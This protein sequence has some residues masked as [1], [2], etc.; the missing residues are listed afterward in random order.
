VSTLEEL[1]QK[2]KA[3]YEQNWETM[4]IR[5]SSITEAQREA[6]RL[7]SNKGIYQ[8]IEAVTHVPWFFVGLCHDRESAFN[9]NTYL[10]NGQPLNQV[11]TI[12]PKGRGPF[13]GPNAFI[14]G[15]VDALRLEGLVG[16]S[17]WSIA[18]TLFRLEAYNGFGYHSKGVNSP[19]L[20]SGSTVYGPPEQRA[21]K[22]VGDGVFNPNEV[23]PQLGVA[24]ILKELIGLDNS[25]TFDAAPAVPSGSPEPDV[26]HAETILQLQRSLNQ[27]GLN[28]K[29]V[30]DGIIGPRTMAAIS[31]FQ[32]QGGLND[33]GV[34]DAATIAAVA[35]RL[36]PTPS[37]APLP[38]IL[39]MPIPP[40]LSTL[41]TT[42]LDGFSQIVQ[43]LKDL[44]QMITSPNNATTQSVATTP[45]DPLGFL[46][47]VL[48]MAIKVNSQP[49]AAS[50]PAASGAPSANQL[51]QIIDMITA[52]VGQ[53]DPGLGQVN[54]AL[55]ETIGNLLNGKKTAIG[56]GGS[57]TT[58]LL[59]AVSSSPN[60]GGLAGLLGSIATS[61]PGLSQFALPI[62]LA[63][64]AWGVLGK[65]EKWSQGIVPQ[66]KL[67]A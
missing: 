39:P 10:G 63:M 21:G 55:G 51:K 49:G 42:M 32:Q 9:L 15:A 47:R 3:G 26:A 59:A 17:D 14:N 61:V 19:Y 20:W 8:K 45:N 38:P 40:I 29:L 12:V 28:P 30:E 65:F 33:T 7:L 36:T 41:P 48:G 50:T 31:S 13:L 18:R 60:A 6:N 2:F 57:L 35:A 62:F 46:E 34:P 11:T 24:V 37:P 53:V 67:T 22:F 58:S 44:E 4:Q 25:I 5:P 1:F 56:M 43:R 64:T 52:I 54:G 66:A 23:D 27:L 16:A